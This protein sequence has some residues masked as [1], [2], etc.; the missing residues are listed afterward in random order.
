MTWAGGPPLGA[1]PQTTPS[2][3]LPPVHG[4]L[5]QSDAAVVSSGKW[6]RSFTRTGEDLNRAGTCR[7]KGVMP[8]LEPT[9]NGYRTILCNAQPLHKRETCPW[10]QL[11]QTRQGPGFI[12]PGPRTAQGLCEGERL[13]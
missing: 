1:C 9:G 6:L 11:P 7:R 12:F 10:T 2:C 3:L 4:G 13:Y 5:L 8:S